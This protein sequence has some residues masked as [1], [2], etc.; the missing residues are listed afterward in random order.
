M[1]SQLKDSGFKSQPGFWPGSS[2]APWVQVPVWILAKFESQSELCSFI[3]ISQNSSSKTFWGPPKSLFLWVITINNNCTTNGN[4]KVLY[5]CVWLKQQT[6]ISHSLEAGKSKIK[7]LADLVP[8]RAHFL[9]CSQQSPSH[10]VLMAERERGRERR[11]EAEEGESHRY[12]LVSLPL[13]KRT[14]IPSWVPYP[15]DF[16]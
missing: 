16:I 10:C 9:G 2:P 3:Y 15:Q 1:W 8:C 12:F 4:W 6:F 13:L 14:L 5:V 7:V 11:G